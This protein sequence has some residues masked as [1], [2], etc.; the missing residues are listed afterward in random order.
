MPGPLEKGALEDHEIEDYSARCDE[1]L[2][3]HSN[4]EKLDSKI[5]KDHDNDVQWQCPYKKEPQMGIRILRK[6][7]KQDKDCL[8]HGPETTL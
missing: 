4:A 2:M 6:R 3:Q 1:L 5:Y 8:Q 7:M